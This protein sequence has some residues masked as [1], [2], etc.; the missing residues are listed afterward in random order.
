MAKLSASGE[1]LLA[2]TSVPTC[3]P[4]EMQNNSKLH[5]SPFFDA[6]ICY[7]CGHN[8]RACEC[9]SC[10]KCGTPFMKYFGTGLVKGRSH[11]RCCASPVCVTCIVVIKGLVKVCTRCHLKQK[12]EEISTEKALSAICEAKFGLDESYS[13]LSKLKTIAQKT[14]A[15]F[16]AA[17]KGLDHVMLTLFNVGCSVDSIDSKQNTPLFY[18]SE[19]GYLQ[20][21]VLLLEKGSNIKAKNNVGWTPL[22]ACAWKGK[23]ENH[24]ECIKYL[25]EMGADVMCQSNTKETAADVA[26]RCNAR[27]EI[28]QILK[29]AEVETSIREIEHKVENLLNSS[30]S[31]KEQALCRLLTTLVD[32]IKQSNSTELKTA[33]N[34]ENTDGTETSDEH[35][36]EDYLTNIKDPSVKEKDGV[37]INQTF[38]HKCRG[39][40][41][42]ESKE[43]H[44]N[45]NDSTT[46]NL[47]NGEYDRENKNSEVQKRLEREKSEW[48]ERCR[49]LMS[50]IAVATK[51]HEKRIEELQLTIKC[52]KE[53]N[54]NIKTKR[55]AT[56]E[57]KLAKLRQETD[58][59]IKEIERRLNE[60]EAE[61]HDVMVLQSHLKLT[62][63][64]DEFVQECQYTKCRTPFSKTNRKH[65]CRCCGRV[66][67]AKC[68]QQKIKLDLLG[69]AKPV[70]VCN[71]CFAL[72]DDVMRSPSVPVP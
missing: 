4:V 30:P 70:R 54:E 55:D 57:N 25:L 65:H 68:S 26:Q 27:M 5:S 18:A 45:D 20:C 28:I 1:W 29:S 37:E 6:H 50:S 23:S 66:F 40:T 64:P 59:Q 17:K 12:E 48:E 11:C 34:N 71:I 72:V 46:T 7:E 15:L 13:S 58:M 16:E 2:E 24:S 42:V 67:C 43:D 63:I 22:H 14:D 62:W 69:Y 52:L 32:F 9:K 8:F 60:T 39:P 33:D 49:K 47:L 53:E 51:D 21:I 10:L 56:Y 41:V 31:M 19:G 61:K 36:R 38:C 44:S 35:L 3:G